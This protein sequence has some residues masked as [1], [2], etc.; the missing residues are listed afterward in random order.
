MQRNA[1]LAAFAAFR[2]KLLSDDLEKWSVRLI[3]LARR[4]QGC[5]H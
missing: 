5:E 2:A 1:G 4:I 3:E